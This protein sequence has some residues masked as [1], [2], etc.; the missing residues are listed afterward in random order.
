[1]KMNK[2]IKLLPHKM[3]YSKMLEELEE[4]YNREFKLRKR[5]G[6]K[7]EIYLDLI[8]SNKQ[9]DDRL[10]LTLINKTA[11]KYLKEKELEVL[12]IEFR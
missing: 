11:L 4:M 7:K 9:E 8:C 10:F 3:R 1:M 5:Y 6:S 2:L 12:S